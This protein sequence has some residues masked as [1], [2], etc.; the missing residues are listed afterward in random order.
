MAN[1]TKR[2]KRHPGTIEDRG[3]YLRVILY[4][5][6]T[7]YVST[8][9]DSADRWFLD[10]NDR[11]VAEKFARARLRELGND[12]DKRKRGV[13]TSAR[14]SGLLEQYQREGLPTLSA[15][16][17][18]AYDDSLKMIREYFVDDLHDPRLADVGTKQ[19]KGFL[20]WRR[21]QRR[22]GKNRKADP[23]PVS[24]RTLQKDRA[25]LHRLF[26][27]A[28]ELELVEGNPVSRTEQPKADPRSPVLLTDEQFEKLLEK[29]V[30]QPQLWLYTLTLGES[31]GRCRSEVLHLR[32]S[33][34][35][36][37]GGFIEIRSGDDGHR[38]KSG[39][40]RFVPMTARLQKAMKDHAA[41]VRLVTYHGKPSPWVF[42][43]ERDR[44]GAKAGDR[45][46]SFRAAFD[47]AQSEA[48][49][50]D[51]FHRH[52]LRHRRVTMW[53]AEGASPVLVKEAM[54][55]SDLRTTMGYTHM[56]KEHLKALVASPGKV[57]GKEP[58]QTAA[59]G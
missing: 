7:R 15:G 2:R 44:R 37:A 43:H 28:Y 38:T 16:T 26:V 49:L 24:N 53:L 56:S 5:D 20:S 30:D 42:H 34:V 23:A 35:D 25:V 31:G 45:V 46:K 39:K 14:F 1:S 8:R 27:F 18:R 57:A 36:L 54:G 40:S 33:D 21:N 6:G 51:S 32:W 50:P 19:I 13:D 17:Q 47:S 12:A 41:R 11:K 10:T 52:D 4:H 55:H 29:C 59:T 9:R 22:T 3:D 58:P 48:G